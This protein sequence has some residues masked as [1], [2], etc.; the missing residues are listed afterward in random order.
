MAAQRM[1]VH[2]GMP[3][4]LIQFLEHYQLNPEILKRPETENLLRL[5][6]SGTYPVDNLVEQLSSPA[7]NPR[8][9]DL[10]LTVLKIRTLS[11]NFPP[12]LQNLLAPHL[13]SRA[14]PH[15]HLLSHPPPASHSRVSPLMFPGMGNNGH[16]AVSPGP[17]QNQRVPSPQEMTVLTQQILQQALIKKKLEEQK[18]NYRKKQEGKPDREDKEN[19]RGIK[20]ADNG[21]AGSPLAFTPTSVMRK[22]A[23]DRK[24][25]D[26]KPGVP[27][28]KIT[29]QEEVRDKP[30]PPSPGR[31]IKGKGSDRPGSLDLAGRNV[32]SAGV[33]GAAPPQQQQ[34]GLMG[35]APNLV[36][37][38]QNLQNPLL[39]LSNPQAMMGAGGMPGFVPGGGNLAGLMGGRYQHPG[40]MPGA[41]PHPGMRVGPSSPRG[42]A[43][44]SPGQ[45]PLSRFFPNDVLA[46]AAAA[47]GAARLKMPPLPTGQAMTLEEIERQAGTVK[48]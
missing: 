22:S 24:D 5:V 27:E 26:P 42:Q 39:F 47:Q 19:I 6:N 13:M 48:I 44:V 43:P 21:S 16:L 17:P 12:P 45:T 3:P 14:S 28:L 10:I 25:S 18:E 11:H 20:S 36:G 33:R 8:N 9:R 1:S 41:N 40:M 15:D 35:G 46:A 37:V 32:R 31:P 4:Q 23:A 7:L 2:H 38:P 30:G 34:P 29:G